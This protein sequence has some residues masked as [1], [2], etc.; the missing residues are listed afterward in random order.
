VRVI[1]Y[2]NADGD[3]ESGSPMWLTATILRPEVAAAAELA[4]SVSE[5]T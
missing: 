2:E 4:N 1:E 5:G 3:R